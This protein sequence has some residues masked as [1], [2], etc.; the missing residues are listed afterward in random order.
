MSETDRYFIHTSNIQP[1]TVGRGS[2]F[3]ITNVVLF[4]ATA[5]TTTYAGMM[6]AGMTDTLVTE[7]GVINL[8]VLAYG[9]PYAVALLGVL[10]THEMGHYIASRLHKVKAS[11]QI[12]RAHV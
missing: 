5:I 4:L 11:L 10:M 3:P 1:E 6:Y 9:L 7:S 12:G 8:H 2:N